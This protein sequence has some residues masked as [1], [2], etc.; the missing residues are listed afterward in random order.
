MLALC[1]EELE[2]SDFKVA[3]QEST[4]YTSALS[5]TPCNLQESTR[6]NKFEY[7]QVR[8]VKGGCER[9]FYISSCKGRNW[10]RDCPKIRVPFSKD[11]C[12]VAAENYIFV[13]NFGAL[14]RR[15]KSASHFG[16]QVLRRCMKEMVNV[17]HL[18]WD[19]EAFNDRVHVACFN[20]QKVEGE[21]REALDNAATHNAKATTY[22]VQ[23][24]ENEYRVKVCRSKKVA[25]VVT[26]TEEPG[27]EEALSVSRLQPKCN[28]ILKVDS[29]YYMPT[30]VAD[31]TVENSFVLPW[32]MEV[33]NLFDTLLLHVVKEIVGVE[34]TVDMVILQCDEEPSLFVHCKL[35]DLLDEELKA[36][37]VLGP[38]LQQ[39]HK[40]N[41]DGTQEDCVVMLR[42]VSDPDTLNRYYNAGFR[43]TKSIGGLNY[44]EIH[45]KVVS[46]Y[47]EY[48]KKALAHETTGEDDGK[49]LKKPVAIPT[50]L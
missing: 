32:E 29:E 4:F 10:N 35:G 23:F 30:E 31:P 17:Y 2:Y 42:S 3:L 37:K 25:N 26:S 49:G 22:D 43:S 18:A 48:Y 50:V 46:V 13:S 20:W 24:L 9:V 41:D 21:L 14:Q 5:G 1:V 12:L 40:T 38:S 34:E 6:K 15:P 27:K 7:C 45:A 8:T 39:I 47:R 33:E 28:T 19:E 36:L 44:L 11:M 16:L